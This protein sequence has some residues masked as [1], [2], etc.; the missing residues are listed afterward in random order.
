[1]SWHSLPGEEATFTLLGIANAPGG[2][3]TFGSLWYLRCDREGL[4]PLVYVLRFE[5]FYF[6]SELEP[7]VRGRRGDA[8]GPDDVH[9]RDGG[10][11]GRSR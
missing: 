1:M 6:V 2:A 4:P 7:V 5:S 9:R 11:R 3:G 10:D 8:A